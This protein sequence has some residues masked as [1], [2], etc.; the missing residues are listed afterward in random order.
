MELKQDAVNVASVTVL[1]LN[2]TFYGIETECRIVSILVETVLIVPFMELKLI[3]DVA[4]RTQHP[5]LNRTFYGIET[6]KRLEK[7]QPSAMS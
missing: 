5:R 1:R 7:F 2:R 4:V 6:S 3:E